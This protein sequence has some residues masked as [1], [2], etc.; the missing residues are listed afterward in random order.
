MNPRTSIKWNATTK[1][2]SVL[3]EGG[4]VNEA[5]RVVMMDRKQ[6][7]ATFSH[8]DLLEAFSFHGTWVLIGERA[9]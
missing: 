5:D 9:K 4:S 6:A 2:L 3:Y 8:N 1:M 7:I